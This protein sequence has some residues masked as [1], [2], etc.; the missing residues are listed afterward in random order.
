MTSQTIQEDR[1]D[2]RAASRLYRAVWRWHFYAGLVVVPFLVLLATTGMIMLYGNSVETMIGPRQ[3]VVATDNPVSYA[4]QAEAAAA[5]VP[6]GSVSQLIVPPDQISATKF[7]VNGADGTHVVAVDPADGAVI[8]NYLQEDV[9]FNWASKIHGTLLLGDFGDR[10]LEIAAG[11]GIVLILTGLYMWWPRGGRTWK[12]ALVPQLS[13]GRPFWRELH[14]TTG[15]YFAVVLLFF[16]LS[17]LSWTGVWGGQMVQAW[18][19]FPAE[20]WDAPLSGSTHADMNHGD[21]KDV[22]WTLEQTPMPMSHGDMAEQGPATLDSVVASA[23]Q[24]GFGEQFRVN[25]PG[26]ATGVYT[27]SQDSMSGDTSNPFGDLTVHL[28]QYSGAVVAQVAFADYGAGGKA[29]AAGIALHQGNLGWWNVALN[30]AFCL[31]II[32][33]SVSGIV[34][35]WKR[36]PKGKFA[37]PLYPREYRTPW[38]V[39]IIALIVC[40]A[41]PL[42]GIAIALF[43]VIDFFMPRRFK[44]AGAA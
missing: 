21:T 39:L 18:N 34:M 29:M 22:P 33:I 30:L 27:I 3:A 35:W 7:L 14:Q 9:L 4:A 31:A 8:A 5:A 23:R 43:A 13:K 42:T 40:V 41:F 28:D 19:T 20:K 17:G 12:R 37:A 36:R 6:D 44:Q 11:L 10:V 26:D 2:N 16:L 38:G 1:T 24:M 15:A 25:L 32:F